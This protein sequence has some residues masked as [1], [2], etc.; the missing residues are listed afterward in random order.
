MFG[1]FSVKMFEELGALSIGFRI[2]RAKRLWKESKDVFSCLFEEGPSARLGD[3]RAFRIS[4]RKD[5]FKDGKEGGR[6][7]R[8]LRREKRGC[9][10]VNEVLLGRKKY[11]TSC[12]NKSNQ[13]EKSFADIIISKI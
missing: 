4:K 12:N 6:R 9:Q 11:I 13:I 7:Y 3:L 10:R 1:T 2:M 5:R 8:V